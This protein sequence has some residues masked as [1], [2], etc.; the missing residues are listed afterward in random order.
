MYFL[1]VNDKVYNALVTKITEDA[2]YFE[3]T[4]VDPFGKAQK[5]EIAKRLPSEGK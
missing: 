4:V 3:E 2:I 5:H 1:K